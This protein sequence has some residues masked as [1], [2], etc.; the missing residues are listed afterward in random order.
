MAHAVA[1]QAKVV[2]Y[3]L[4]LIAFVAPS[5]SGSPRRKNSTP[6]PH[7]VLPSLPYALRKPN[8]T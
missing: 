2:S 6:F 1:A 5:T 3:F 4:S 7:L 8:F